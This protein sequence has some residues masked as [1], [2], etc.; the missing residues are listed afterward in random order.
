MRTLALLGTH[1]LW[2]LPLPLPAPST[3]TC[4]WPHRGHSPARCPQA[5]PFLP[6]ASALRIGHDRWLPVWESRVEL[7]WVGGTLEWGWT[8]DSGPHG[9]HPRNCPGLRGLNQIRAQ[10]QLWGYHGQMAADPLWGQ[11]WGEGE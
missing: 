10:G 5:P 2:L 1:R 11:V 3:Q 9:Q 8:E 4:L 7:S 6:V